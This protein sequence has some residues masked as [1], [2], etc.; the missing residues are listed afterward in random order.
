MLGGASKNNGGRRLRRS[1]AVR[2]VASGRR[3]GNSEGAGGHTV[4]EATRWGSVM[5][6]QHLLIFWHQKFKPRFL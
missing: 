6:Q 4:S 1:G 3:R 5:L 2:V